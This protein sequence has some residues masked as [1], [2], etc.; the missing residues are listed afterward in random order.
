[1][2]KGRESGERVRVG[3]NMR[4]ESGARERMIER[5]WESGARE[6]EAREWR[7]GE[8]ESRE[9]ER[10]ERKS[11]VRESGVRESGARK[12]VRVG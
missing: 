3:A 6:S 7:E 2:R 10:G 8:S 5:V 12:A 9:S 1:M 11:G 4:G